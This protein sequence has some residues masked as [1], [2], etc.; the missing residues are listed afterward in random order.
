[1]AQGLLGNGHTADRQLSVGPFLSV[2]RSKG[3]RVCAAAHGD[4]AAWNVTKR[5]TAAANHSCGSDLPDRTLTQ[6]KMPLNHFNPTQIALNHFH[7]T[8][9]VP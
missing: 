1:M 2:W 4:S 9:N 7:P 3:S 8:K 5:K 6:H